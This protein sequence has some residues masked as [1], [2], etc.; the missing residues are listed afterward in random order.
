MRSAEV[1]IW[2]VKVLLSFDQQYFDIK[3]LEISGIVRNVTSQGAVLD[4]TVP[5]RLCGIKDKS[6]KLIDNI[7]PHPGTKKQY[8][9]CVHTTTLITHEH[10]PPTYFSHSW[11]EN[12]NHEVLGVFLRFLFQPHYP[13]YTVFKMVAMKQ[14]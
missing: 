7:K 6:I 11:C 13:T 3:V 14:L 2:S 8:R 12:S 9:G 5:Y 1:Q 10:C 4:H